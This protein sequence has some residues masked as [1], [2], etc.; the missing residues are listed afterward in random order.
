MPQDVTKTRRKC[1]RCRRR[2]DDSDLRMVRIR[3]AGR[4]TQYQ[5]HPVP[6]CFACRRAIR[7]HWMYDRSRPG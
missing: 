6:M 1:V 4:A 7:G 3:V 5:L 2:L